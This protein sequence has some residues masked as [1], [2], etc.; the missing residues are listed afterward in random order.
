MQRIVKDR[1]GREIRICGLIHVSNAMLI[2]PITEYA[3]YFLM[4]LGAPWGGPRGTPSLLFLRPSSGGPL[5][6]FTLP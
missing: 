2:D 6:P 3:F 4:G 5:F 1:E